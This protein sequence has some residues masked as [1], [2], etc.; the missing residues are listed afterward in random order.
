ME[1]KTLK[2]T[3]CVD[4]TTNNNQTSAVDVEKYVAE[5]VC[6][7]VNAHNH[8]IENCIKIENVQICNE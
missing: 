7:R 4:Y 1:T 8:S 6:E 5:M 2:L 3:I